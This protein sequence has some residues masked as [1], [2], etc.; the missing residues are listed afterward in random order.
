VLERENRWK[1]GAKR[2][3]ENPTTTCIWTSE[4]FYSMHL[5]E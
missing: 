4:N 5:G 3:V 1:I 2:M